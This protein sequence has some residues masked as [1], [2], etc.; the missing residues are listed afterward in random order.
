ML[1]TFQAY[2][3]TFEQHPRSGN[4]P[5]TADIWSDALRD[6]RIED[7][8][9]ALL[10]FRG[11]RERKF[12]PT[13]S[14][15]EGALREFG[16][17][18]AASERMRLTFSGSEHD[19]SESYLLNG[20]N[21]VRATRAARAEYHAKMKAEGFDRVEVSTGNFIGVRYVR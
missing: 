5:G 2:W 3:P 4:A 8:R 11:E 12:A 17:E 9:R 18:R 7:A 14:E 15:F 19:T 20:R 10:H 6:Y 1:H 16:N 21:Y 13:I